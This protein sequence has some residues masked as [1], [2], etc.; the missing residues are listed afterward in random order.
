MVNQDVPPWERRR[1]VLRTLLGIAVVVFAIWLIL[2]LVGAVLGGLIHLLWIVIL[3]ALVLWIWQRFV[4]R[5][6]SNMS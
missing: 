4:V 6:P 1:Y 5:R 3:I 2:T